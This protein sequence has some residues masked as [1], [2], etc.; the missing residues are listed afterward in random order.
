VT[1]TGDVRVGDLLT[2]L[3]VLIPVLDRDKHY[4]IGQDE[5]DKLL[6]KGGEWLPGHPERE[7]IV[8]RYLKYRRRLTDDALMRLA[9]LD[10]R[11]SEDESEDAGPLPEAAR[12]SLHTQ[13][14]DAVLAEVQRLGA[15]SVLDL[16]C[17]D[18]KLLARLRDLPQLQRIVGVD[19]STT[20]LQRAVRR[21]RYERQT[22]TTGPQR[23]ELLHGSL[24]YRDSRLLGFDVACVVE[25]VEHLDPHRLETFANVLFGR[26]A[27]NHV[28]LTTPNREYN[29]RF[30]NLT[31]GALRHDDH[32]FEWTRDEFEQWCRGLATRF[33]YALRLAAVGPDD[34]EVG[35][36]S[37]MAVFSRSG[38]ANTEGMAP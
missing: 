13:R 2:H 15:R 16:G 5:V 3:Y 24:T 14:H 23:L 26:T 20:S 25:V 30:E 11:E 34:A 27:P 21:L 32:R 7:R 18:G 12:V 22:A 17:A 1:L 38:R 36:P 9:A 8:K 4:W 31:P 33:G 10:D 37:Q 19:V 29:I 6:R 28:I 35:P